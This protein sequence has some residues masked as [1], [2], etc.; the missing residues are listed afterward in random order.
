MAKDYLR[1]ILG[2]VDNAKELARRK[3]EEAKNSLK[4]FKTNA[5]NAIDRD[6]DMAGFQLVKSG[7][8]RFDVGNQVKAFQE[9]SIPEFKKYNN[10]FF[11]KTAANV[12]NATMNVVVK[13]TMAVA[14]EAKKAVTD[15]E[16]F[17]K[18]FVPTAKRLIT[19]PVNYAKS[20][21]E[22][23][24][25]PKVQKMFNES[26]ARIN[27]QARMYSDRGI[28]LMKEG[29]TE[30][31]KRWL[32]QAQKL[33]QMI[34]EMTNKRIG[35]VQ[36][37]KQ[38]LVENTIDTAK[39][40]L[41][42][43]NPAG[44]VRTTV[45]SGALNTAIDKVTGEDTQGSFWEGA[46][47]GLD[48]SGVLNI[49][50]PVIA[51][52]VGKYAATID[53]PVKR[54]L[55]ARTLNGFGNV[56]EDEI[57]NRANLRPE[58]RDIALSFGTAF[59]LSGKGDEK[60]YQNLITKLTGRGVDEAVAKQVADQAQNAKAKLDAGGRERTADWSKWGKSEEVSDLSPVQMVR[61]RE[62]LTREAAMLRADGK[63][64]SQIQQQ[65][66]A[67]K[68]QYETKFGL[69]KNGQQFLSGGLAGVEMEQDE[70]GN[71]T[72]QVRYDPVKGAIGMGVMA[73]F[74]TT[75]KHL[76]DFDDIVKRSDSAE[77]A[78]KVVVDTANIKISDILD[79]VKAGDKTA[80]N[81][82]KGIRAALNQEMYKIAGVDPKEGKF[83]KVILETAKGDPDVA[84]FIDQIEDQVIRIDDILKGNNRSAGQTM[85]EFFG[86]GTKQTKA[87]KTAEE[88]IGKA[89]DN[90]RY[91][92]TSP[93]NIESIKTK[94]LLPGEGQY[95]RG[96]Y[97]A[98][99][100]E[101][102]KGYG[103]PEGAMLRVKE[104]SLKKYGYD[105]FKGEQ[106]W[107]DNSKISPEDI[108]VKVGE[109]W[110]PLIKPDYF[111]EPEA[112]PKTKKY[113]RIVAGDRVDSVKANGLEGD[114]KAAYH[115]G[116]GKTP[117]KLN[118]FDNKQQALDYARDNYA[119]DG[120][121][122]LIEVEAPDQGELPLGG[123]SIAK[124]QTK[125]LNISDLEPEKN[126][127]GGVFGM[128]PKANPEAPKSPKPQVDT[129]K[130]EKT[131]EPK[132]T[133]M[134]KFFKGNGGKANVEFTT[135]EKL[136]GPGQLDRAKRQGN[137]K[138]LKSTFVT[139]NN[140]QGM[141]LGSS[142]LD[143]STD[144]NGIRKGSIGI[145][146]IEDQFQ[147]Q[148]Y[149][150][151]LLTELENRAKAE[152]ATEMEIY[153]VTNP[154]YWEHMGYDRAGKDTFTK[155]LFGKNNIEQLTPM[156]KFFKKGEQ[157]ALPGMEK[158][159]EPKPNT[160]V[161]ERDLVGIQEPAKITKKNMADETKAA[162]ADFK[163][164]EKQVFADEGAKLGSKGMS[165][166]N[167][168]KI[169]KSIKK[170]TTQDYLK[171]EVVTTAKDISAGN[172]GF[173][174][175]YRNF[176][177]VF[178]KNSKAHKDY[179]EPFDT[180]KA[181]LVDDLEGLATDLEENVTKKF[182]IKKGSK[183]SAAIQNYGE[184]K[185]SLE[186]L[187]SQFGETKANQIVEADKWFRSQYDRLLEE[188]NA[189]RRQIYPNN[190]DKI[191]PKR[192]DYYRHFRE[193]ANSFEGLKNLFDTPA[194]ISPKLEGL[195]ARTKPKAK[196]LSFAQER[197]GDKTTEDAI[198]GFID[199]AK[200]QVYA[201]NIDPHIEK[202]RDLGRT[203][204]DS[205]EESGN[206]N[207]F[208]RFLDQYSNDL[209]GKTNP[210]DRPIQDI[211]GRKPMA[212]LNWINSRTKAN[213]IVGNLSSSIAQFFNI[214][215]GIAEANPQNAFKGLVRSLSD[216]ENAM[217]KSEFIKTRYSDSVFDRFDEGVLNN[218]K[219]AASWITGIGDELGTKY[220][221][222]SLYE[223]ALK[224][225]EANPIRYADDM[226]RKMVAGRGIGEV[227]LAQKSK[228]FQ[229]IAPFQLE[230]ANIWHVM[231]DWAGESKEIGNKQVAGKFATFFVAAHIMNKIAENVRGSDVTFDPIQATMDAYETFQ[232][233]ENKGMGALKAGGRL[234]GEVI[235]NIPGGQ[236]AAAIYPE[237]GF[238]VGDTKLPTRADFFG[239]G[240]PTRFGSG[241]LAVK[242]LSDPVFKI[243][244]PFGGQQIKRTI[245]GIR[246]Y[247][248]GYSETASGKVK[249][250]IE[251]N[252]GN[253]IKTAT[254]G[255]NSTKESRDY[256]DRKGT[257]LGEKQSEKFKNAGGEEKKNYYDQIMS[258]LRGDKKV[259]GEAVSK[260]MELPEDTTAL[261]VIYKDAQGKINNYEESR[262]KLEYLKD[263]DTDLD[264]KEAI[265]ELEAE[266]AEAE[267][268][269]SQM[270]EK[271]PEKMLDIEIG[272]YKSGGGA[273]VEERA[274]WVN[275]KLKKYS[276][277][278]DT[279]KVMEL[280][281]KLWDEKVLTGGSSGVAAKLLEE[282]GIDV[283]GFGS[284]PSKSKNPNAKKASGAKDK[285]NK[286]ISK[287]MSDFFG[288]AADLPSLGGG[289][290]KAPKS[291]VNWGNMTFA[292]PVSE[293]EARLET[294]TIKAPQM[295][296]EQFFAP[297]QTSLSSGEAMKAV[298]AVR[299]SRGGDSRLKL[300]Y[301]R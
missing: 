232:E 102:T 8:K 187:K 6:K 224:N 65:L 46:A 77:N 33:N 233:E 22:M 200:A 207:N 136:T 17:K 52:V 217:S 9:Y 298:N 175:V 258:N 96:V 143:I 219:K 73:G 202:F 14:G 99:S 41:I 7:K 85:E 129:L 155:Q 55:I 283:Y 40:A 297:K 39:L 210:I 84:P 106:G 150:R 153:G 89:T 199:Y 240:D 244:P 154:D 21:G 45:V 152:G 36:E 229:L 170:N 163:Q 128:K 272:A 205:T 171:P 121:V 60:D 10:N 222:N 98:P 95:G 15:W 34:S 110:E 165:T 24:A 57:I 203:L 54:Q 294:P 276:E 92:T 125:I 263:F 168:D 82:L 114:T 174:D 134:E 104:D 63:D 195:S 259:A 213:V 243:A 293:Q 249:F 177:E 70:E 288:S 236:T 246:S 279:K 11:G 139:M 299:S 285:L 144:S 149:S 291:Q 62:K 120:K 242:G 115:F 204:A 256:F 44:A 53:S 273:N 133:K 58:D 79:K 88:I 282:Y 135:K 193:V 278:G 28:Q 173:R 146:G 113:Y 248:K 227:P 93:E 198:G 86:Q 169:T 157:P 159:M 221:W 4:Q 253:A 180:A 90:Y 235:S 189:V 275:D 160:F 131:G 26:T 178:G 261:T 296:M 137:L 3:A 35:E 51:G 301:S 122:A 211:V 140:K 214:P 81:D 164:W 13:P 138:E 118:Y 97:L 124:D 25:Q 186:D 226:T 270:E 289:Q 107:T 161:P 286:N 290:A 262:A 269:L 295:S 111:Q 208:I 116:T 241:M 266:K 109:N 166:K 267:Q 250:P 234:A 68:K 148:G 191:I 277:S 145:F 162:V 59:I 264:K 56:I 254:F 215:Q 100:E 78:G 192:K 67:L 130:P 38:G 29:K 103:A 188:V 66:Q 183:E 74:T 151:R 123:F 274:K 126:D 117:G 147:G 37:A 18:D 265:A 257:P 19:A 141:Q 43:Y 218:V 194:N 179:L 228:V 132:Q 281:D 48:M 31:A 27:E 101:L 287:I 42:A 167:I 61:K 182:N 176:D 71:Y 76:A 231:K 225:G 20:I 5:V 30:E 69:P 72:G 47:K 230:V 292:S 181:Q 190:E 237:Y 94:G 206:L 185:L 83:Q 300:H 156:E 64:D 260:Q 247:N 105:E 245:E 251:K 50:N 2:L 112:K 252:L 75:K 216:P 91:H 239:E 268:Y 158:T 142:G 23:A 201:K 1:N 284:D 197:K 184:G 32:Q 172:T 271:Y 87:P 49:T 255:E 16:G 119:F 12:A 209:A 212:V 80:I 280:I 108:E 223:K 238:K 127:M 220:I 196:W